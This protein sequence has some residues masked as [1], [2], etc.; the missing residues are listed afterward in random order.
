MIKVDYANGEGDGHVIW[1]LGQ[2][3]DFTVIST[4][5]NPWFSH[6]HNAHYI[7]AHTLI[8]FDNGN[9]RRASDQTAHSRG[10]V[11]KLDEETMTATSVLN[12]DLGSYAGALGA[13]QLLSNGDYSFTLGTNGAEP[14]K[15]PAHTIEVSPDGTKVYD[16]KANRPE[17]RSFRMRTL[18][19]G[20]GL[21]VGDGERGSWKDEHHGS[22]ERTGGEGSADRSAIFAASLGFMRD[23]FRTTFA[24]VLS[25]PFHLSVSPAEGVDIGTV[26][27]FQHTSEGTSLDTAAMGV[28]QP[29]HPN[30]AAGMAPAHVAA[31]SMQDALFADT[32]GNLSFESFWDNGA[33]ARPVEHARGS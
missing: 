9:T 30:P 14:P 12:A 20:T 18:Y 5:P 25:P 31:R 32:S 7:D 6:Q 19:A 33:R 26:Q 10:Q 27:L 1:R 23:N 3:G 21:P 16:L 17:Y 11:W 29:H 13:A 4:D 8:L 28:A 24:A 15:P 22:G 2:G